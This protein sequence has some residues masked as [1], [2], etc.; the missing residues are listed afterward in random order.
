MM[1]RL[2]KTLF[3]AALFLGFIAAM[4]S[5]YYVFF[6]KNPGKTPVSM[7]SSNVSPAQAAP[8]AAQSAP[9]AVQS[10]LS[11]VNQSAENN[12]STATKNM[13][14]K[15]LNCAYVAFTFDD[16]Y[17][18]DYELAFPI[19]KKYGIRGTSYIIPKYE[20]ENKPYTLT[21]AEVKE[22]Y[23]YG[24]IF[25]CHTYAHSNLSLLTDDEIAKSMRMVNDAFKKHGLSIPAIGAYP[26]GKYNQRVINAIRPYR[27]QMRKAFYET[28]LVNI[29][30]VNPYEI[31]SVSADMRSE[32]RLKEHEAVVDEACREKKVLVFRC[33]CLYRTQ[34]N[35]MGEWVVQTDSRLFEQLVKYCVD[36][37]CKFITMKDLIRLYS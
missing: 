14:A 23:A 26:Y 5:L 8:A 9:A 1:V 20:D 32:K 11:N 3:V 2:F 35:D 27:I 7:K 31:D 19:L 12:A 13:S 34:V 18:S 36:K 28:K 37:G 33:H 25:G 30:N 16:G 29:N 10:A 6:Y 15:K 22:M 24:W 21:W 17:F 4:L